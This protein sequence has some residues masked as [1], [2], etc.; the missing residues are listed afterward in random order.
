MIAG[1]ICEDSR[2]K[3]DNFTEIVCDVHDF[4]AIE[5]ENDDDIAVTVKDVLHFVVILMVRN[6]TVTSEV[7]IDFA[8]Y[9]SQDV[10]DF[11]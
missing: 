7:V 11:A 5:G 10:L 2:W 8:M 3:I 6:L 9:V 1:I 4:S